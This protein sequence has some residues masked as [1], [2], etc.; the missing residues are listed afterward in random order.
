MN[1]IK[2]IIILAVTIAICCS[3]CSCSLF[4]FD[5]AHFRGG[6]PLD[7]Q[8]LSD[9]YNEIFT[10]IESSN[11]NQNKE[12]SNIEINSSIENYDTDT[13]IHYDEIITDS[14]ENEETTKAEENEDVVYWIES[15][16]VWH[17]KS[18]CRYIANKDNIISGSEE[19]AIAAGMKRVCSTC[20]KN[21]Q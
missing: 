14:E 2:K 7:D 3:M 6:L 20:Q 11:D 12:E 21:K 4:I 9:I 8:L 18:N 19:A 15:G 16:S 17:L 1:R 5:Q 13:P 10:D